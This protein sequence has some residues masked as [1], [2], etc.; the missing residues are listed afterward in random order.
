MFAGVII[1]AGIHGP[2][3]IGVA[4]FVV[5][6]VTSL[7]LW[8][9]SSHWYVI[10]TGVRIIRLPWHAIR[11]VIVVIHLC[12]LFILLSRLESL[13]LALCNIK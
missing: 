3:V 2:I 6:V 1:V 5:T 13:F 12:H 4:A 9:R 11:I 8:R 10:R 7:V